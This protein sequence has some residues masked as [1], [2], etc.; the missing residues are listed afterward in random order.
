MVGIK[1]YLGQIPPKLTKTVAEEDLDVESGF[2]PV[3]KRI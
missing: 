3:E 1:G 2:V